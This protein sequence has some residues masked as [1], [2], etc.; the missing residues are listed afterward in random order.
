MTL[1]LDRRMSPFT[2]VFDLDGTLVD[3]APDLVATLNVVLAREGLQPVAYADARLMVG[4]GARV[5]VERGIKANGRLL[6]ADKIDRLVE[7][8][9]THYSDHIVDR[10]QPFDGV[11]ATLDQLAESG[12]RLA[13]CTNKLEWLSLRLLDALKLR[14]RFHAIC[15][16]DTFGV[17]KPD[18]TILNLTIERA[19][20]DKT[21]AI[22]IGDSITDIATAR[23]AGIPVI[24]VDFGYS[25]VPVAELKPDRVVSAFSKL[26]KT[27]SW[28]LSTG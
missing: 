22:M 27:I 15:G 21:R 28:V 14:P 3:T 13:V 1:Q 10:S 7:D 25:D 2:I 24:A 6:P 17:S 18:P 20:G 19:G 5:I 8:F 26:P 12:C 11:E 4:G 9:I 23:A 16:A